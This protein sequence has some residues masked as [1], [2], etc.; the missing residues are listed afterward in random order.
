[1]KNLLVEDDDT[2]DDDNDD[3]SADRSP[4]PT[5]RRRPSTSAQYGLHYYKGLGDRRVADDPHCFDAEERL[6]KAMAKA[7][8]LTFCTYRDDHD[9][10][11]DAGPDWA[12]GCQHQDLDRCRVPPPPQQAGATP[13]EMARQHRR[14]R[15]RPVPAEDCDPELDC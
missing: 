8:L 14:S 4:S 9:D 5:P 13:A 11:D 12:C 6:L 2:N 3:T 1:M 15:R 7:N 10:H